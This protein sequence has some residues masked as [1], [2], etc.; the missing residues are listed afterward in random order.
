MRKV[1]NRLGKSLECP[2]LYLYDADCEQNGNREAKQ[3]WQKCKQKRV[4]Q[5]PPEVNGIHELFEPAQPHPFPA[6]HALTGQEITK[7]QQH[8][9]HRKVHEDE[10]IQKNRRKHQQQ[11]LIPSNQAE[12]RRHAFFQRETL[13][14]DT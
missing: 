13:P 2:I 12:Q 5:Q 9:R 11:I 1:R 4:A 6:E 14:F 10:V 8:A 7:C 3:E